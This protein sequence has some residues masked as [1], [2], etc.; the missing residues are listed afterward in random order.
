MKRRPR[1]KSPNARR[2]ATKRCQAEDAPPIRDD[3]I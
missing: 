3:A 2:A 1:P